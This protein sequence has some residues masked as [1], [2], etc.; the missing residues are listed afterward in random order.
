MT[1]P[2]LLQKRLAREK[3]ARQEAERLLEA[4]SREL[5]LEKQRVERRNLALEESLEKLRVTQ[6]QLVDTSRMAGMAEV[7]SGVLHDVGNVLNSVNVTTSLVRDRFRRSKVKGLQKAT[8]LIEEKLDSLGEF[9]TED[10]QGKKIPAYLIQ[11]AATLSTEK[12]EIEEQLERLAQHVAH[13]A[14]IVQ[15]Q[16][17]YAQVS[18]A[19]QEVELVDLIENAVSLSESDIRAYSIAVERNFDEVPTINIAPHRVLQIL[20]N[21]VRN[22][23]DSLRET[24]THRLLEV[25]LHR[26][27]VDHVE[28]SVRDSGLGIAAENLDKIFRHGFSTKD[29]GHGFGLHSCGNTAKQLGGTLAVSS[30]G[31][32]AGATFTLSFPIEVAE[33]TV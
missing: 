1:S 28:I 23:V 20:V 25:S 18:G 7:A 21:L 14:D 33:P 22:A 24:P 12:Q 26:V 19:N 27:G 30:A 32:G 17:T 2:E 13:I 4:K 10:P 15:L 16:Q 9:L 3:A 6:Q 29:D 5:F 8:K 11:L 31:L